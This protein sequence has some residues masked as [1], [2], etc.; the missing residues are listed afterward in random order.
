M[1]Y[2]GQLTLLLFCFPTGKTTSA[3]SWGVQLADAGLRTLVVSTDPAHS[4]G[5]ALQEKLTGVPRLLDS[6]TGGGQLWAMEI[7]PAAALDEFRDI[8]QSSTG[9]PGSGMGG[10]S[11]AAA[12]GGGVMGG[13]GLP[14]LQGELSNM[15]S[16]VNDPPPGTDEIVA[17]T[18]VVSY[19]EKGYTSPSGTL[20][21][22]DRVVLDTAPTGHTLRML[23]LPEFLQQVLTKVRTV[24][25]K[26]GALGGMMS[27]MG[28]AG[29]AGA[30]G[31]VAGGPSMDDKL[32]DFQSRMERLEALLHDPAQCE[33]TVVT[34]PTELA[35]A[36]TCRLLTALQVEDILVRRLIIN[37]VLPMPPTTSGAPGGSSE[38]SAGDIETAKQAAIVSNETFL[39]RLRHGQAVS[40]KALEIVSQSANVP[41]TIV[42]YFEMEV[43]TVYGLRAI[44]NYL[45]PPGGASS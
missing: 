8:L 42:P 39:R 32:S 14:D 23:Q 27:M 43:R 34:I 30:A 37:Q 41:L 18:K 19:L 26:A 33:F 44:S 6:P 11:T 4:L 22:F 40:L 3:A 20:H 12:G 17:M 1:H 5:D 15:L 35:T 31:G 16:G 38:D 21:R 45:F 7:D 25:D 10:S 29:G 24:K 13:M 28:G 2:N 9:A 36:E